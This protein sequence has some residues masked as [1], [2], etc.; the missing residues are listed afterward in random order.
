MRTLSTMTLISSRCTVS[1]GKRRWTTF[2]GRCPQP[3]GSEGLRLRKHRRIYQRHR[4]CLWHRMCTI[5]PS[6]TDPA[7]YFCRRSPRS[8]LSNH[9]PR[10]MRALSVRQTFGT[11]V[12]R[13]HLGIVECVRCCTTRLR[14]QGT[15]PPSTGMASVQ[16]AFFLVAT[17]RTNLAVIARP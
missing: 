11:A 7:S 16:D 8:I 13:W 14:C 1:R 3:C 5:V 10:M 15:R 9:H 6:K 4:A 12:V 2:T 17:V